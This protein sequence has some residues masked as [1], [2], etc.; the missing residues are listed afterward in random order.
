MVRLPVPH[1][2][3]RSRRRLRSTMLTTPS[4]SMSWRMCTKPDQFNSG[5][6]WCSRATIRGFEYCEG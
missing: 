4:R 1:L 2:Q 6:P 3:R 5:A